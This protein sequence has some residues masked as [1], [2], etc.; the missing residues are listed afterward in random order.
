MLIVPWQHMALK[1]VCLPL[2][3]GAWLFSPNSQSAFVTSPKADGRPVFTIEFPRRPTSRTG[4][5][6][7]SVAQTSYEVNFT[8]FLS[9][10]QAGLTVR[11]RILF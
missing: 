7:K 3:Q 11:L 5:S 9:I 8:K 10:I 1:C 6:V 2:C 4:H